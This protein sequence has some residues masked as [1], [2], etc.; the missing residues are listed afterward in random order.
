MNITLHTDNLSLFQLHNTGCPGHDLQTHVSRLGI[1]RRVFEELRLNGTKLTRVEPDFRPM[2]KE[3]EEARIASLAYARKKI[4]DEA[5]AREFLRCLKAIAGEDAGAHVMQQTASHYYKQINTQGVS[6]TLK[7][8][9]LLAFHLEAVTA[10][11]EERYFDSPDEEIITEVADTRTTEERRA[12]SAEIARRVLDEEPV[13]DFFA[14]ELRHINRRTPQVTKFVQDDFRRHLCESEMEA[15]SAEQVDALYEDYARFE[16]YDENGTV[17]LHMSDG[18][19]LVA[20]GDLYEDVD[21]ESLP[22]WARHLG[23]ELERL[24]VAGFPVTDGGPRPGVTGVRVPVWRRDEDTGERRQVL[25]TVFGLDTWIERQI[26]SVF[27]ECIVARTMRQVRVIPFT[28]K[29]KNDRLPLIASTVARAG[30]RINHYAEHF[31]LCNTLLHEQTFT[32]EVCPNPEERA[33]A[34]AIL[35]LL[36]TKLQADCHTRGQHT[37][38]LYR[39]LFARL[40]EA[41]DTEVVARLK[42][43]AWLEKEANRLSLSL[44]TL[45]NT[46]ADA[47]QS[48]LDLVPLRE[49]RTDETGAPHTFIVAHTLLREASAVTGRTINDFAAR[50]NVLPRQERERVR[51]A[52]QGTNAG[53]YERVREGL[54]VEIERASPKRLGYFRWAMYP[55]NKPEHPVH[56]LTREDQ[57]AAWALLKDRSGLACTPRSAIEI[58]H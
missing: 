29:Y 25:V 43:E 11:G 52:V 42:R 6:A 1:H 53:L 21:A 41:I 23:T 56:T 55:G 45:F 38:P 33:E 47:R 2:T 14:D 3:T 58:I 15:S 27:G 40:G 12:A 16:Q 39:S 24:Y 37:S 30:G 26:D 35:E 5:D 36:L 20:C 51:R 18:E 32:I 46:S 34:H 31:T 9:G 8:M 22:E 44:F 17:G 48:Y 57:A 10:C 4:G 13:Y 50:L 49:T 28:A 19:R 54:R 7:E